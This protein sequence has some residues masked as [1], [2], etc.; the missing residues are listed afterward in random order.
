M[1]PLAESAARRYE[2]IARGGNA[3]RVVPWSRQDR[4]CGLG[5]CSPLVVASERDQTASHFYSSCREHGWPVVWLA[6]ED[7]QYGEVTFADL[8]DAVGHALGVYFRE[9]LADDGTEAWIAA[10]VRAVVLRARNLIG[11]S[12]T[13]TNWSKPLHL[14]KLQTALRLKNNITV[15]VTTLVSYLDNRCDGV[16]K[17]IGGLPAYAVPAA[18]HRG[19]E[20]VGPLLVQE[21]VDGEELRVHVID[22]IVIT[23]ALVKNGFDYREDGLECAV[24]AALTEAERVAMLALCRSEGA[25][26]AGVDVI[27]AGERLSVLEVNPMPG[28]S[29]FEEI[30]DDGFPIS[31][32]LYERLSNAS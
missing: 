18:D 8:D 6:H 28:Y 9:P 4:L 7:V 11:P 30:A 31:A 22:D 26:F 24:R 16:L 12:P 14:L 2:L 3:A 32:A 5:G 20:G 21:F 19:C 25:R 10:V 15:P 23:Y 17:A 27:R 1:H 13:S 29:Y